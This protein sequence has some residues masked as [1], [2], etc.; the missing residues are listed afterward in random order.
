MTNS[1]SS[2]Y[3]EFEDIMKRVLQDHGH[4][5]MARRS[6]LHAGILVEGLSDSQILVTM[7][8]GVLKNTP[9]VIPGGPPASRAVSPNSLVNTT[10]V[11]TF[12]VPPPTVYTV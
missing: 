4:G 11:G 2:L 6:V 7:E 1:N 3:R 9:V 12:S 10:P 8:H 5:L